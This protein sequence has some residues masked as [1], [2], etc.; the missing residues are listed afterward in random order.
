MIGLGGTGYTVPLGIDVDG[1]SCGR[2]RPPMAQSDAATSLPQRDTPK[3]T[4][5]NIESDFFVFVDTY[6][7]NIGARRDLRR[8]VKL[9]G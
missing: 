1:G 8:S 2:P 5:Q 3:W 4:V 7:K 6:C 9:P